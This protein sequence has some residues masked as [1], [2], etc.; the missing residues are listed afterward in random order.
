MRDTLRTLA[1]GMALVSLPGG[2][3]VFG[4]AG[5]PSQPPPQSASEPKSSD[6]QMSDEEFLRQMVMGNM[7]EVELG[8]LGAGKATNSELKSFAQRLVQDHGKALEE[9]KTIAKTKNITVPTEVDAEHKATLDKLSAQSG[10]AF[11]R[12][13]AEV[14]VDAHR[15]TLEK[16]TAYLANAKDPEI[17]A[18][19]SKVLPTVREHLKI[20]EQVRSK[21]VGTT[22]QK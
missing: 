4:Q 13:Y 8:K 21:A 9:L 5:T 16:L 17:R 3:I 14:M 18:W 20:A 15:K 7:A 22:G 6:V 2:Q 11:D 1:L 12:E 10:A 19:A